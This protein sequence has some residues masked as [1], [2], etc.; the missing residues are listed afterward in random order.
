MRSV[1]ITGGTGYFGRGLVCHLLT[2]AVHERI[3]IYSRD[4]AKQAA[5]RAQIADPHDR[6]R[7]FV[8]DV[9][10]LSRLKHAMAGVDLVIHAAA[11]KR[12]EVGEYN[13]G[14][15]VKTNVLGT[16]N[17]IEAATDAPLGN[18]FPRKVVALSTDKA[19]HPVNAY[20]ASKL[21]MEKLILGANNT[22]GQNGPIFAVTRYGNVAGSTGSVIQ[23][24][25]AA[26]E[27][28]P[29][30]IMVTDYNATRFWMTLQEAI[31]LVM[32]TAWEM[33]GGE[34]VTPEL[35]AYSVGNLAEAIGFLKQGFM[36][37][38]YADRLVG[39]GK[40]EKL[41]ERMLEDG[42]SSDQVRR[43]TVLELVEALEQI[44]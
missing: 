21:M 36:T 33:K 17:L 2:I 44:R 20:G 25:R 24:W 1:L 40:G 11:L 3:C 31:D 5:M 38:G 7:W 14:E 27:K 16:M 32:R 19:C 13:P 41:H 4:E 10:D 30:N 37:P 9:R 26:M 28:D 18:R 35:P 15:M 29:M 43:M 12:V 34:F 22:R 23:Q 39:L 42:P 8:G 6:L